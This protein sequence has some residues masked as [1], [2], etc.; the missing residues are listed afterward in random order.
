MS[1]KTVNDL[2]KEFSDG[3]LLKTGEVSDGYHT[4]D[5]LYEH[6]CLLF[7][8]LCKALSGADNGVWRSVKNSDGFLEKG[9][10]IMGLGKREGEQITYHLPYKYW[11]HTTFA[12]TLDKG[13]WDGHTPDGVVQRLIIKL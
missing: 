2:I 4:F 7:I 11:D 9:W 3:G 1:A 5:E 12:E 6:R 10:F 8:H 13:L